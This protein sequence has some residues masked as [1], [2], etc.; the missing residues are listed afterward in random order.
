VSRAQQHLNGA[1]LVQ[2]A[3]ALAT[4]RHTPCKTGQARERSRLACA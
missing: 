1:A 4:S 3:D 2:Q